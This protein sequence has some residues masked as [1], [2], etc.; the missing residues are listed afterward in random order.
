MNQTIFRMAMVLMTV[1][2]SWQTRAAPVT[3]NTA[4]PVAE[5]EFIHRELLVVMRSGDD[6][7]GMNRDMAVSTLVSVLGY[8][9]SGKLALFGALPYADKKLALTMNAMPLERSS[10]GFGD[11]SL[12]GRYTLFQRDA[13]GQ[14][15]R[16]AV[17]AGTEAPT[18]DDHENDNLGRLPPPLQSG[19]GAWDGFGGVV[20]TWQ[21]LDYQLDGQIAYRNN[22]KA[23]GF[24]AGDQ[25]RLD[26]S[27]QYRLWPGTLAADTRGFLY[28]VL[29]ANLI[30]NDPNRSN[31]EKDENSGGTTLF[32]A[33]GLQY[34]TR[35]W[36]VEAVVQLPVSQNLRGTALENDYVVRS[37]FRWNF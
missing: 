12:F 4:L 21:I 15:F 5:G 28:G 32:L 23:N 6:P 7:S 19:S 29:E 34:V 11:L 33:P 14:T 25:W 35:R 22:G 13:P 24:E 26:G 37:G 8:G 9:I 30:H 1:L 36:I 3:F 16:I 17:F 31:G 2:W 20:A 18:S 27:L 10:D